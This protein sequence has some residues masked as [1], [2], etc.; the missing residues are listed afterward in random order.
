MS[1]EILEAVQGLEK[2][3]KDAKEGAEKTLLEQKG[4]FEQKYKEA[5]D[6]LTKLETKSTADVAQLNADLAKKGADLEEIQKQVKEM[7]ARSGRF[8]G[9]DGAVEKKAQEII[10]DSLEEHFKEIQT[11]GSRNSISWT[12]EHKSITNMTSAN[13]LTGNPLATYDLTPAVRGRRK[14]N[15]RDLVP[16][17]NSA[18]GTWKFYRENIPAGDGSLAQQ[19]VHGNPKNQ[20]DYNLTEVTVTADYLA[21]F[22][23]F[24]KQMAQD[25][26][27]LQSFIANELVEDYKRT[28]SGTFLPILTAGAAG[29]TAVSGSGVPAENI[30]DW[31]ANLLANDYDPNAIITTA[32]IWSAILRTKPQ[33]YSIPGA[34]QISPE[35]NI[36]FQGIP[37]VAQ[38][39]MVAGKVLVGDFSKAAII[40]TEGMSI[41]FYEQ[42]SD[43][44]QRNLITARIEAR[45]GMAITRPDAFVYGTATANS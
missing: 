32:A 15:L 40:Q 7:R 43:N 33:N 34:I 4:F 3:F 5:T 37:L 8:K 39:N 16:V 12:M 2:T 13:N 24:A 28:E 9:M 1:K 18:T 27:F 42:D 44:V 11:V 14:I 36:M 17:I 35:G 45:V 30:I 20:M 19:L 38:N 6:A 22:V 41:N 10:S 31:I 29:S 25:L 23:R 26:P 21:G